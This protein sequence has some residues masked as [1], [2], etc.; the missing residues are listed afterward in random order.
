MADGFASVRRLRGILAA[1]MTRAEIDELII[2]VAEETAGQHIVGD[3]GRTC[4]AAAFTQAADLLDSLDGENE[5]TRGWNWWDAATIPASCAALLRT[6]A[7][8]APEQPIPYV[9]TEPTT[10]EFTRLWLNTPTTEA[11]S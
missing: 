9:L 7:G 1:F 6:V 3:D 10:P 11:S 2:D 8:D 4:R 5:L